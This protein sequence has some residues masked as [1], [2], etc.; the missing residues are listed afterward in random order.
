MDK[1]GRRR[2]QKVR[3]FVRYEE[4]GGRDEGLDGQGKA[5]L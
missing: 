4:G 1:G 5:R 3:L 2:E